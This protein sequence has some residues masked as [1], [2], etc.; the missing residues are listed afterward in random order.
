MGIK[1]RERPLGIILYIYIYIERERERERRRRRRRRRM[2]EK[3]SKTQSPQASLT[4]HKAPLFGGLKN[5]Y[6]CFIEKC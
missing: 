2:V 4:Q 5:Y 1:E 6:N 3:I